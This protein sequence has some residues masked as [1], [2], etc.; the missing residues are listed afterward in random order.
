MCGAVEYITK[1]SIEVHYNPYQLS[2]H[3]RKKGISLVRDNKFLKLT[4]RFF[5]LQHIV[6]R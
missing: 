2:T 6:G 4:Y 5:Q 1:C 3:V